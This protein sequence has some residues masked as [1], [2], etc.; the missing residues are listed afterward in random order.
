MDD[1]LDYLGRH[2]GYGYSVLEVL[3]A[4]ERVW[5]K[6]K[7]QEETREAPIIKGERR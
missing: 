2:V 5:K 6:G 4:L 3:D 1:A 7:T